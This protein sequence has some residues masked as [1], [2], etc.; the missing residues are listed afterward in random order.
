[1][2][3]I[4]ALE[5]WLWYLNIAGDVAVVATLAARGLVHAYRLLFLY[6]LADLLQS[7]AG[8]LFPEHY[9]WAYVGGQAVKFLLSIAF[10]LDLYGRILAPQPALAKFGRRTVAVLL[11]VSIAVSLPGTLVGLAR[12]MDPDRVATALSKVERTGDFTSGVL[13]LLMTAFLLW[14]PVKVRRNVAAYVSGFIVYFLARGIALVAFDVWR[15][16]QGLF[17]GAALAVAF[18]CMAFWTIALRPEGEK[19]VM[20]TGHR[21]NPREAERLSLQL[22]TLNARLERLLH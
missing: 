18:G 19:A 22:D 15:Q 5:R 14:F 11:A 6:F 2:E 21:W 7:A 10:V 9:F 12:A 8:L 3:M 13:L 4:T 16:Y 17:D 1:M 20:V